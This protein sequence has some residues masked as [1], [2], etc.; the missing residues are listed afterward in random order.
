M[1]NEKMSKMMEM[2]EFF[3]MY[4]M[5][6]SMK[7]KKTVS[8][9]NQTPTAINSVD[10]FYDNSNLV[11]VQDTI[12][13]LGKPNNNTKDVKT[14]YSVEKINNFFRIKN[15]INTYGKKYIDVTTG[16]EKQHRFNRIAYNLAN[17]AI[18]ALK[19][20]PIY[21]KDFITAEIPIDGK[22]RG[23]NAWGFKTKKMCDMVIEEVLPKVIKA[24]D[25]D[26]VRKNL[27][28]K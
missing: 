14:E 4:E 7:E 15:G 20:H 12:K 5:Y 10:E 8:T 24:A 28:V 2:M 22:K 26:Q 18:K 27:E 1:T 25:I 19:D 6:K 16:K 3:E 11:Q 13:D 23:W 21:G 17:D 9:R